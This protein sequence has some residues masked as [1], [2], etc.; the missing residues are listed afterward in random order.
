M[1]YAFLEIEK[2]VVKDLLRFMIGNILGLKA[3][4][5]VSFNCI[6]CVGFDGICDDQ[7]LLISNY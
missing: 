6:I 7:F 2:C 5:D 3:T 1:I 4:F